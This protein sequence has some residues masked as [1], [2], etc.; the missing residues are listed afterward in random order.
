M[1][2]AAILAERDRGE[3]HSCS[4]W[5]GLPIGLLR[6]AL[7]QWSGAYDDWSAAGDQV[8]H[9]K[10]AIS[11]QAGAYCSSTSVEGAARRMSRPELNIVGRNVS[12]QMTL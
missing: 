11:W 1:H 4:E 3:A 5:R 9:D 8:W 7:S 12:I 10:T 2:A 6:Y